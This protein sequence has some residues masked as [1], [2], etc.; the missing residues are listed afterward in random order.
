MYTRTYV[1]VC[2]CICHRPLLD[3][4]TNE[5]YIV[6]SYIYMN[7]YMDMHTRMNI[8]MHARIHMRIYV[9]SAPSRCGTSN[10]Y[11]KCTD[12]KCIHA[13]RIYTHVY[14]NGCTYIVCIYTSTRHRP[15][16][17]AVLRTDVALNVGL[18]GKDEEYA[19]SDKPLP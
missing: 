11:T 13:Y 14:T 18:G 4:D 3:A 16:L 15:L 8:R 19:D 1:C 2:L 7:T 6:Y 5:D 12:K 17:D 9:S 10:N